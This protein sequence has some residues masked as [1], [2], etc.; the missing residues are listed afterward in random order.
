M[1][2]IVF[3]AVATADGL[4]FAVTL[5]Q[6]IKGRNLVLKKSKTDITR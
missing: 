3:K 4:P 1:G 2:Q 5:M 6:H